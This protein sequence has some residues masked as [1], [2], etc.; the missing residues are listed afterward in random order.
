M[1]TVVVT[2]GKDGDEWPKW[3]LLVGMIVMTEVMMKNLVMLRGIDSG[4]GDLGCDEG[5]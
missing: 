2:V 5:E 4:C 1:I 3:V